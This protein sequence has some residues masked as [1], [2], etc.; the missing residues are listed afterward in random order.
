MEYAVLPETFVNVVFPS[1]WDKGNLNPS[2][3]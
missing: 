3:R 2:K 1:C